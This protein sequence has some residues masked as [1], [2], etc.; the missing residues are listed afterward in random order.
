MRVVWCS[1]VVSDNYLG[2]H[3]KGSFDV[4]RAAAPHSMAKGSGCFVHMRS[5][6]GLIANFGQAND[7]AAKLGAA[8][9]SKSIALDLQKFSVRSNALAPLAWTQD[10][11]HP[12]R[13][14]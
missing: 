3:L 5:S 14:A 6:S 7:S 11:Q 1:R 4:S 8:A 2:R 9:L 13:D 12:G 10:R